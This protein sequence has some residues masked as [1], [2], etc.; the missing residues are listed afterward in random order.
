MDNKPWEVTVEQIQGKPST[1]TVFEVSTERLRE[2]LE[3]NPEDHIVRIINRSIEGET[4]R[5]AG[6]ED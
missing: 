1:L 6:V 2:I 5:R 4:L 3:G